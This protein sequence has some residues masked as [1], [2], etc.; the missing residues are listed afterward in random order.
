M[1]NFELK[2]LKEVIANLKLMRDNMEYKYQLNDIIESLED[3]LK[4]G[5]IDECK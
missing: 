3:L 5:D 4:D 2:Y 1:S